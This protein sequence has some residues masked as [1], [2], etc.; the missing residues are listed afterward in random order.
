[1]KKISN[2]NPNILPAARLGETAAPGESDAAAIKAE[3]TCDPKQ[4]KLQDLMAANISQFKFH[5]LMIQA[6]TTRDALIRKSHAVPARGRP[7]A[8]P[9]P[10]LAALPDGEPARRSPATAATAAGPALR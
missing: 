1:V 8:S 7:E 2:V 5:N 10:G 3:L 4:L 9:W 6:R